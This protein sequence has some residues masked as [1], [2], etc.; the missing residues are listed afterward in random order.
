MTSCQKLSALISSA[1]ERAAELPPS[2]EEHVATCLACQAEVHAARRLTGLLGAAYEDAALSD[3]A[4]DRAIARAQAAGAGGS[5]TSASRLRTLRWPM[6]MAAGV[7]IGVGAMWVAQS[8]LLESAPTGSEGGIASDDDD[9]RDDGDRDDGDDPQVE[10]G[11]EQLVARACT[12][13]GPEAVSCAVGDR[14]TTAAGERLALELSDGTAIELNH[15]TTLA[16]DA[17]SPRG[18]ILEAGEVLLDVAHRQELPALTIRAPAGEVTVI[19]TQLQVAATDSRTL[20]DVLRGVVDVTSGGETKRLGAGDE[21][22]LRKGAA[23]RV[24]AAP[25][26]AEATRWV[27]P[28]DERGVTDS[29]GFGSLTARKPGAREDREAALRLVDHQVTAKIQGRVARTTVEEAFY[30]DTDDVMEGIY[31]F[32][33]PPGARIAALDLMV[34][35]AWEHGAIVDRERGEKIWR[36]V[37]RNATAKKERHKQ[38]IEY[39]WV[40]GPW[41]DPALLTWKR[42]SEFEL[43]IFPIPK[44]GERRVRIAYTETLD[45]VPGGRRYVYPL[46]KDPTGRARAARFTFDATI[47]AA[48]GGADVRTAPYDLSPRG[49]GDRLRMAMSRDDF[50]PE[51]DIVIDVPDAEP[52]VELMTWGY[53]PAAATGGG[54]G[55]GYALLA[56]RPHLPSRASEGP[57]DVLFVVDTSYSTQ[58]E[59]LSRAAQVVARTIQEM[60]RGHRAHVLVCGTRCEELG[61]GFRETGDGLAA[62]VAERLSAIEP[63]GTT[64]LDESFER[65]GAALRAAHVAPNSARVVYV[66]D[67]VATIGELDA[68]RVARSVAD[69]LPGV[70]VTTVSLGGQVDATMLEGVA[71]ETDGDYLEYGRFRTP[72]AMALA[73]LQRQ[74]G[75]PLT[76]VALR[77]PPGL[78]QVAPAVQGV[79]WPGEERLVAARTAGSVS[80]EVVLSGRL[81][82][83]AFERTYRIDVSP[84]MVAG[85]AFLPRLWA[86]RRIGDL[87]AADATANRE[88]IVA[89]SKAHHVVSRHTSLLVLESPAMAKAFDV[90]DTRPAVDWTGEEQAEGELADYD[91]DGLDDADGSGF[92]TLGQGVGGGGDAVGSLGGLKSGSG[93]GAV[94]GSDSKKRKPTG[95]SGSIRASAPSSEPKGVLPPSKKPR[96]SSPARDRVREELGKTLEDKPAPPPPRRGGEYV[97]MKKAWY[98]EATIGAYRDRHSAEHRELAKREATLRANPES[99]DRT[100][101]LVQW[102]L[103]MG[104]VTSA[105]QLAQR[106]L[107]KDRMDAGA[108]MALADVAA[109]QGDAARSE[110]LLASAVEVD[111]DN[112]VA[113]DRMVGLYQAAGE[114]AL[115]CAHSVARAILSEGSPDHAVAA[116]RCAGDVERFFAHLSR[117]N[118]KKADKALAKPAAAPKVHDKIVVEASWDGGQDLDVIVLDPRGRRVSWQG[119]AKRVAVADAKSLTHERLALSADKLGRYTVLMV[120]AEAGGAD[121]E[122]SAPISGRLTVRSYNGAK[123][124]LSFTTDGRSTHVASLRIVSKWRHEP[125]R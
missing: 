13:R 3:R 94:M 80:G 53:Q 28:I 117:K 24:Y 44:R 100:R 81:G 77:L 104:M 36:G 50:S 99:R 103:R 21:A 59:R 90:H 121:A 10:D 43:R 48:G 4:A 11:D 62:E 101:D 120:H 115:A 63:L 125:V 102:Y 40:P 15:D 91:L 67:G 75:E 119:G 12:R 51:G 124:T 9:D 110:A 54:A 122:R 34:D 106:W 14:F 95:K 83:E 86:E 39:I 57:L 69:A 76:E 61:V 98:R 30:N 70:R 107:E 20:V 1:P 82:G 113:R 23:P 71:R 5:G 49:D 112:L 33:I 6:A 38:K 42:G 74:W 97:A 84:R 2:L 58:R 56:L 17:R 114:A 79:M 66:G 105:E 60:G 109:L 45:A 29:L 93:A 19:G 123:R 87:E 27:E 73:I 25:N 108:L 26:L 37:I 118:R 72:R 31:S 35:G 64:A 47:G 88:A 32:P 68:G 96:S 7:L 22:I 52:G 111:H 65:A 8:G 46:S 18:L 89:L 16:L 85:N 55:D 116:A 78:S 92:G 41:R